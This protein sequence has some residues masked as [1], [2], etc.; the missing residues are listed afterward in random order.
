[1]L[2]NMKKFLLLS[3]ASCFLA[4]AGFQKENPIE[5]LDVEAKVEFPSRIRFVL[6][7]KSDSE[8]QSVELEFGLATAACSPDKNIVVPKDFTP[9]KR[10]SVEWSWDM[11]QNGPLPQ[12]PDII[13]WQWTIIDT[14]GNEV[15]TD[16]QWVTWLDDKNPWKTLKAGNINIYWYRG[17]EDYIQQFLDIAATTRDRLQTDL[18]TWPTR[19]IQIYV[20]DSQKA[21][22]ESSL[23]GMDWAGGI[24]F[25]GFTNIIM[26]FTPRDAEWGRRAIAHELTHVAL[27]NAMA[28]RCYASVPLWM[29]EGLAMHYEGEPDP[30]DSS[31]LRQA[32]GRDSLLSLRS[33][34]KKYP[35]NTDDI[36]LFYAQSSSLVAFLFERFGIETIRESLVLLRDGYGYDYALQSSFGLNTE[37][38]ENAWRESVHANPLPVESATPTDSTFPDSTLLPFAEPSLLSTITPTLTPIPTRTSLQIVTFI[39][40]FSPEY[41][42]LSLCCIFVILTTGIVIVFLDSKKRARS[43][44]VSQDLQG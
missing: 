38:L 3:L 30:R 12:S 25:S 13:W 32:I 5:I 6:E 34:N 23:T 41:A 15:V 9:S 39:R 1:M 20:Y 33:M 8:I 16:P 36:S 26:G 22:L 11:R 7:A 10:I 28:F 31:I 24:T 42:I 18:D 35:E 40:T 44:K 21:M 14:M 4:A 19:D 29:N 2:E 17:D 27:E 43:K 37:G